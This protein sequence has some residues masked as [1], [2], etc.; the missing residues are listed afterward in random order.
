MS[1]HHYLHKAN[2]VLGKFGVAVSSRIPCEMQ[3]RKRLDSCPIDTFSKS[4]LS[5]TC[6]GRIG[7]LRGREML[8]WDVVWHTR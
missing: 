7:G 1:Q 2:R 5:S 3:P 4:K 6:G 8:H